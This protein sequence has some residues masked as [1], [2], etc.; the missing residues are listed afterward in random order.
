MRQC[1]IYYRNLMHIKVYQF[2]QKPYQRPPNPVGWE[3]AWHGLYHLVESTSDKIRKMNAQKEQDG[4][5][6]HT[7]EQ[8]CFL[9]ILEEIGHKHVNLFEL[10]CGRAPW[11]LALA[12]ATMHRFIDP[13]PSSYRT[14]AV[15]AE[16][17]HYLWAR[18]HLRCQDINS[19]IIYAA[20]HSFIGSCRFAADTNPAE[21]MGQAV[22]D[23]GNIIVPTVTIDHLR[24]K[25]NF[26]RIHILHMD[27]QGMEVEALKGAVQSLE[28]GLIDYLIIGTHGKE[29]EKTTRSML[30]PSHELILE[31]P[32]LGILSIE[33][34]SRSFRS[35]DD[36]VQLFRRKGVNESISQSAQSK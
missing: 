14:L 10:G 18:K 6:A 32:S 36:G 7:L 13:S 19:E 5:S 1:T 30:A 11:C 35:Y 31:L 4:Y 33:G 25:Y 28:Q 29:I 22:S 34:I 9:S 23:T 16:P 8:F 17:I 26:D 2:P 20:M 3:P 12:S 27:I 24:K 15:E 21:H